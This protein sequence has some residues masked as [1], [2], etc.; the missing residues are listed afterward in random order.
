[1][2]RNDDRPSRGASLAAYS[3]RDDLL[4]RQMRNTYSGYV[5]TS[6]LSGSVEV[7]ATVAHSAVDISAGSCAVMRVAPGRHRRARRSA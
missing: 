4:T 6:E 5:G 7:M 1:M 2:L 3:D